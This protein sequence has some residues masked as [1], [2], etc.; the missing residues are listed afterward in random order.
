MFGSGIFGGMGGMGGGRRGGMGGMF[1]GD[2]DD[3]SGFSSFLVGGYARRH[4]GWYA[5]PRQ[6]RV[7][8]RAARA[9]P[10]TVR[11]ARRR[12]RSRAPLKVALEDL[13]AG[14]V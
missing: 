6:L 2:D 12:P 9:F 10:R 5:A 1:G 7:H 8:Q 14:T 4:A 13:A 3:M 11:R